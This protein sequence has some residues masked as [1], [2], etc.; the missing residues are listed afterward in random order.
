MRARLPTTV[1]VMVF[2]RP[3][4][5]FLQIRIILKAEKPFQGRASPA[6]TAM[7]SV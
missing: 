6:I 2:T 4:M 5:D 1:W 3:D 7:M